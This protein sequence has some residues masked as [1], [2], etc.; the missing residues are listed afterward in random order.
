MYC[1]HFWFYPYKVSWEFQKIPSFAE[2]R[3]FCMGTWIVLDCARLCQNLINGQN[4][5]KVLENT[6]GIITNVFVIHFAYVSFNLQELGGLQCGWFGQNL[7]AKI[8]I[9][10]GHNS[11]SLRNT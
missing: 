4:I 7:S 9:W 8:S 3:A 6:T 11:Y 10:K 1:K 5:L 2:N